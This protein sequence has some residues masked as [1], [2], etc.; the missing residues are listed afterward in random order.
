MQGA[1]AV[2]QIV[3]TKQIEVEQEEELRRQA[4]HGVTKVCG[5]H[6]VLCSSSLQ[7]TSNWEH[8]YQLLMYHTIIW[9][10]CW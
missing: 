5:I 2:A 10:F 9:V 1:L 7:R 3:K 4:S 6:V 8:L